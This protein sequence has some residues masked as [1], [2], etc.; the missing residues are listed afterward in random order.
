[1][2]TSLNWIKAMV[3]GL[4]DVTDQQFR[5]DYG[6]TDEMVEMQH[7]MQELADANPFFDMS[8]GVSTDGAEILDNQLR[9]AARGT[10]WNET[11]DA[12]YNTVDT[13][14]NEINADPIQNT[15]E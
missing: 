14:I 8:T 12:I 1:M 3:P 15:A 4:D 9:A 5:D 7:S 13:F 10:P 11:Y 2:N 6:W